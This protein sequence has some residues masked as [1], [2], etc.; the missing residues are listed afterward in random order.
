VSLSAWERQAL[1]SIKDE[2]AGSDPELAALL[3]AFTRLASGKAMPARERIR[4]GSRRTTRRRW[5]PPRHCCPASERPHSARKLRF[6]DLRWALLLSWLLVTVA[7]IVVA[8]VLSHGGTPATE[9]CPGS[10]LTICTH[11]AAG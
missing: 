4:S 7:L 10:W 6:L 1:D 5:W 2:L 8:L 9:S 3:T 11:A